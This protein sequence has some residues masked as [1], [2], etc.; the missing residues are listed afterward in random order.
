M[1]GCLGVWSEEYFSTWKSHLMAWFGIWVFSIM[2]V[3]MCDFALCDVW[4]KTSENRHLMMQKMVVLRSF[5]VFQLWMLNYFGINTWIDSICIEWIDFLVC[6][7]PNN[8]L[9]V[10]DFAICDI[11]M[12]IGFWSGTKDRE[13]G[14]C[15]CLFVLFQLRIY[16]TFGI[17]NWLAAPYTHHGHPWRWFG[18]QDRSNSHDVQNWGTYVEYNLKDD[19]SD[20]SNY[21]MWAKIDIKTLW[22]K[23][24][25]ALRFVD[26][27]G[28]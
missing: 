2:D 15:R 5:S 9:C 18:Y 10:C 1:D 28:L 6:V 23:V 24:D 26:N 17:H 7:L 25:D 11:W 20:I 21:N 12:K 14:S 27:E 19:N 4:V 8:D 3:A 22:W 13:N 16:G